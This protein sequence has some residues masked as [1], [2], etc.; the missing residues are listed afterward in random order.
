[1]R[2]RV[3]AQDRVRPARRLG[4]GLC[5][6]AE[7]PLRIARPERLAELRIRVPDRPGKLAVITS[8]VA[9]EGIGI[10]DIEIADLGRGSE[11]RPDPHR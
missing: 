4:E 10:Y 7:L 1:M 6:A 11:W 2:K 9:E 3:A 5:R 8:V